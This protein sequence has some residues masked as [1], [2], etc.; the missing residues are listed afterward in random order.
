MEHWAQQKKFSVKEVR[1]NPARGR[2]SLRN[3]ANELWMDGKKK[4]IRHINRDTV[5]SGE[6]SSGT[7]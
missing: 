3:K 6:V 4:N 1:I 7:S 5:P 2:I